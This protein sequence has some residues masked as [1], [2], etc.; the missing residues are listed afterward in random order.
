M[1]YDDTF[2]AA[3]AFA[4]D[5]SGWEQK[6]RDFWTQRLGRRYLL[7][8]VPTRSR[9]GK[10]LEIGAAWYNRYQKEVVGKGNELTI[11]DIKESRHPD[12]VAV[13]GLDRYIQFDMTE[14]TSSDGA[15]GDI[16]G[17]FDEIRSWGVL[18]HY[19][20]SPAQC[21]HYLDNIE[22]LLGP[23]GQAIFKLD[24]DTYKAVKQLPTAGL[25]FLE[26]LIRERFAVVHTDVLTGSTPGHV[27]Y[28]EK[29]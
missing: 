5:I 27:H 16:H 22:R 9:R 14:D 21:Q 17:T 2:N 3:H 12:I 13:L 26:E 24:I 11:I 20:F 25:G 19:G 4:I 23:S 28:V 10:I 6:H 7:S 8:V 1:E 18:S 15:L 29:R